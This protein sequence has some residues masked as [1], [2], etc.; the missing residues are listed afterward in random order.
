MNYSTVEKKNPKPT[1][2]NKTENTNAMAKST[3]SASGTKQ[4]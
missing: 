3:F 4:I 2:F 1:K